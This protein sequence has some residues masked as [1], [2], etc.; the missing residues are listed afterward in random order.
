[1]IKT[2]SLGRDGPTVQIDEE[3]AWAPHCDTTILHAPGKCVYCD[4]FPDF[5]HYRHFMRVAFT[6][7]AEAEGTK[8][9]APD[10]S[11]WFRTA[12]VRDRWNGNVEN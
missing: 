6:N 4:H 2:V 7:S 12:E 11:L 3:R 5:Q 1:M 8:L 10:P 9:I